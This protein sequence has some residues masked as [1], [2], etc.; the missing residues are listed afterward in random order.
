MGVLLFFVV[1]CIHLVLLFVC[2]L[3]GERVVTSASNG[4]GAGPA[5]KEESAK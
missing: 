5:V 4:T 3:Q 2:F 1:V